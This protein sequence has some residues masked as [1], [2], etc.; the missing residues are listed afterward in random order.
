[1]LPKFPFTVKN[2]IKLLNEL[3]SHYEGMLSHVRAMIAAER[4]QPIK[5]ESRNGAAD[6]T[7]PFS[8]LTKGDAVALILKEKG[9]MHYGKIFASMR[10]R[11]HPVK[12]KN[13]LSNLLSTDK[14]FEKKGRGIWALAETQ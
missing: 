14:R 7:R 8:K 13:S 4:G 3:E 1:M 9:N 11:G 6:A 10:K 5:N 12:S 2:P